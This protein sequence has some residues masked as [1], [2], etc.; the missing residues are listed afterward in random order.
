MLEVL[1]SSDPQTPQRFFTLVDRT[2]GPLLVAT[3]K[4]PIGS[5]W[6]GH[7]A[8]FSTLD[9]MFDK[10][11]TQVVLADQCLEAVEQEQSGEATEHEAYHAQVDEGF[12]GLLL[13]F[14]VLG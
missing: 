14:V 9:G 11:L 6:A 10:A 7:R 12:G 2:S 8:P 3:V 1:R 4:E 5:L 13:A